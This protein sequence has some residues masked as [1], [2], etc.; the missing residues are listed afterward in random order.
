MVA[1]TV[2][3]RAY[4]LT[5]YV[6]AVAVLLQAVVAGRS[7]FGDWDIEVHGWMGNGSFV[8]GLVLVALTI[9]C[10]TGRPAVLTAIALAAALF[11]QVGLGYAGRS[12]LSA[13]AWHVP[14]GVLIFGLAIFNVT[15]AGQRS[16]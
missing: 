16:S 3:D 8:L 10:R 7:L 13:A 6:L 4:R 9:R 14:L 12:A 5:G 11:A 15:L 2:A 1:E